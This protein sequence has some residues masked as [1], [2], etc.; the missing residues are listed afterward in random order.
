SQVKAL[1]MALGFTDADYD[2]PTETLS[3]GQKKLVALARLT[4][5]QPDVLLLDEPDNHLDL[6]AK[7]KLETFIR[8]YPGAAVIVSHDRYLLDEAVTHI[9]EL[10]DGKLT[11]FVGNYTAYATELE[12]R[13]LRQQQ[14]YVAQQKRINQIETFIH[15]S[16]QKAKADL[17]ERHARQAASR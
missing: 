8:A 14:M 10:A 16:E 4:V 6:D 9:A 2:L 17:G 7:R 13:R 15:I 3:G 11:T 12:H 5:E 1:L